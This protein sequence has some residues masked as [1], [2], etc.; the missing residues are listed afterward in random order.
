[1][2]TM[3]PSKVVDENYALETIVKFLP[4]AWADA[5]LSSVTVTPF[6][7]G[8]VNSLWIVENKK[9]PSSKYSKV[10]LRHYGGNVL[11]IEQEHDTTG[12]GLFKNHET[13]EVLVMQAWAEKG[14]GPEVIGVFP[15]GRVEEYI[16]SHTL[17]PEE[18]S[19]PAF[20]EELAK[21]FARFHSIK[22]PLSKTK[23]DMMAKIVRNPPNPEK[24]ADIMAAIPAVLASDA[25]RA[26]GIDFA[27][28]LAIDF[29]TEFKWV[30][31]R[32]DAV[33]S[34]Q[35]LCIFDTNFLNC[36]VRNN[37]KPGEPKTV[38][39]D[40]ELA[41]YGPRGIDIG[42]HFVNRM[43]KWNGKEDKKSGHPYPS[44]AE[45]RDFARHYLLEKKRLNPDTFDPTFDNE[46]AVIEDTDIGTLYCSIF[47]GVVILK[48]LKVLGEK[49]PSFVTSIPL[50]LNFYREHKESCLA[51]YPHWKQ[52]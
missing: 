31:S 1:M 30:F 39:V 6:S 28:V 10:I 44:E 35:V 38:L 3:S 23:L 26:F 36:L 11:K 9:N 32:M 8:Y 15:G 14:Y 20:I 34:P 21:S 29:P 4:E 25:V 17:T 37:P 19:T 47:F 16:D 5:D 24:D 41:M 2:T 51:K 50:L 18:A 49:E 12:P 33:K 46:V 45:Q 52:N 48:E 43:I 7:G 42:G 22:L 13:E 27:T 40:Y